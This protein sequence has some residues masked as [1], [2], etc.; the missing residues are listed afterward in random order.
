M[1]L[2]DTVSTLLG[3]VNVFNIVEEASGRVKHINKDI[4]S[5]HPAIVNIQHPCR[6]LIIGKSQS[7]KTTLAADILMWLHSQVEQVFVCSPTFD[8]QPTWQNVSKY[9]SQK[10]ID[11]DSA[12]DHITE[13]LDTTQ[14]GVRVAFFLDDVSF[15]YMLNTGSR[16]KLAALTYNA[17]WR[18][19]TLCVVA[20]KVTTVTLALRE[21]VEHLILF[22]T[23]NHTELKTIAQAFS[24]TGEPKH[25][26]RLY[27]AI[28]SHPITSGEDNYPFIYVCYV[29][30]LKVYNKFREQLELKY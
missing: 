10:F 2:Y 18:N 3:K 4:S 12:L 16:G 28:I 7:G 21:N 6:I 5:K 1:F 25:F 15:D 23:I 19:L 8:H 24:I 29:K 27:D 11:L 22:K 17:V 13:Y 14:A 30:G 9:V 26:K 20:H